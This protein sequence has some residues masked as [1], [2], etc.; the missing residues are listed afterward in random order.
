[1]AKKQT[2][3]SDRERLFAASSYIGFFCLIPFV[4][5][6]NKPFIH[7]HAKQGLVLFV[8]ELV[9]SAIGWIPLIGW[10]IFLLGWLF[11]V[12]SAILGI[13]YALSGQDFVVPFFGKMI[14]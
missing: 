6:H 12:V 4:L 1:M 3:H 14:K 5:A 11:V 7:K 9:I 10:A 2:K 8:I 13:A